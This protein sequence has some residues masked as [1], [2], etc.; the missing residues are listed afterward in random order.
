MK[1]MKR[2]EGKKINPFT[3]IGYLLLAMGN[4]YLNAFF[5]LAAFALGGTFL[6]V[7]INSVLPS[8][9][10]AARVNDA[11]R[12]GIEFVTREDAVAAWQ[13][14]WLSAFL[15]LFCVAVMVTCVLVGVKMVK[16]ILEFQR[17]GRTL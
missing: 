16:I 12:Q 3:K 2:P 14:A 5:L 9:S 6:V 4:R 11:I 8:F 13:Q 15:C 7:G 17:R 10:Y 1:E